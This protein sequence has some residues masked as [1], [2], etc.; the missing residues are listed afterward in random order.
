MQTQ[1]QLR[2]FL[3]IYELRKNAYPE[4][5]RFMKLTLGFR[6]IFCFSAL[7]VAQTAPPPRPITP[8]DASAPVPYA[9]VSQV[10]LL[11]SQVE[12]TALSMQRDLSS[13]RIEKWKTDG[14]TK[15]G[16]QADVASIQRNL[17]TDLPE[18]IAKL[19]KSPESLSETFKLYRNLD[20][21]GDVFVSLAESSGAFGSRDE[22]QALQNDLNSLENS[23]RMFADRMQALSESKEAELNGLR[24]DL[25]TALAAQKGPDTPPK[26][27]I[28]DDTEPP[29]KPVQ[30]KHTH[31]VPKPPASATPSSAPPS[32]NPTPQ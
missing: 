28:V 30:K 27:V 3:Q 16:S 25:Q 12:Q 15:R 1:E 23:R 31:R 13:L 26:K 5:S 32:P 19:R 2:L 17:E 6:S 21:L 22:Y 7:L 9:S 11:L 14:N 8:P 29:K 4:G 20:A 10:N 18:I 24:T